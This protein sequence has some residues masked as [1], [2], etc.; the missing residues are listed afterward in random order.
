M[1]DLILNIIIN[2][3]KD[4]FWVLYNRSLFLVLIK[5]C[6]PSSGVRWL[7]K[8]GN[9]AIPKQKMYNIIY[10]IAQIYRLLK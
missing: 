5:K 6:L 1:G 8:E 3:K 10:S 7:C 4:K 2:L 9:C